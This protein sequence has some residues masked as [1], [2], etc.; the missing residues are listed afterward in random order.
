ME[1][2]TK[3]EEN[4]DNKL[5]KDLAEA[6]E[7]L[8]HTGLKTL[9]QLLLKKIKNI[10]KYVSSLI[11]LFVDN[12]NMVEYCLIHIAYIYI[13]IYYNLVYNMA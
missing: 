3:R 11:V 6:V 5:C 12:L 10:C 13:Y 9:D 1:V 8:T 2:A 7:T 4:V